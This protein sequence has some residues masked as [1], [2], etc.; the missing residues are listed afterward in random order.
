MD[1]IGVH[2]AYPHAARLKG[3]GAW[4]KPTTWLN[5]QY[6]ELPQDF[7]DRPTTTCIRVD[8]C[9]GGALV[10]PCQT[11]RPRFHCHRANFLNLPDVAKMPSIE[12]GG[13]NLIFL[14]DLLID[15]YLTTPSPVAVT[16]TVLD[17][18]ARNPETLP[19]YSLSRSIQGPFIA[20]H[21][22]NF[23]TAMLY[24]RARAGPIA[25]PLDPGSVV[26]A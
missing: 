18:V 24:P 3:Y 21:L 2:T 26:Q 5:R 13:P 14:T 11:G 8:C 22:S 25:K 20:G 12:V 1:K 10:V 6:Y 7:T 23:V 19:S 16:K 17:S 15:T 4:C 9:Q